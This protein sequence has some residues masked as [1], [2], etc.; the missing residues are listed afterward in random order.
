M[1]INHHRCKADDNTKPA[2]IEKTVVQNKFAYGIINANG[3]M[4][5]NETQITAL[6]KSYRQLV[7]ANVP[8]ATAAKKQISVIELFE[9]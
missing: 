8:T 5:T 2:I 4:P 1:C 3:A 7:P 6:R 9:Y